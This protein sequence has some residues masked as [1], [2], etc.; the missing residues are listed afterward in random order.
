MRRPLTPLTT[1]MDCAPLGSNTTEPDSGKDPL[2]DLLNEPDSGT[3]GEFICFQ[4]PHGPTF[5]TKANLR[6]HQNRAHQ[7]RNP[8]LTLIKDPVCPSCG[9][10]FRARARLAHHLRYGAARCVAWATRALANGET[11]SEEQQNLAL[12]RDQDHYRQCKKAGTHPLQ[13]PPAIT[14]DRARRATLALAHELDFDSDLL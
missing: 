6:R 13:G 2:I 3:D 4:C 12:S 10:D 11:I 1:S 9:T 5:A 7:R 14:R 8:I